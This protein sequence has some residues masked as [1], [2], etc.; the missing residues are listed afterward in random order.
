MPPGW[1][2]CRAKRAGT[3]S[4]LEMNGS[5]AFF[6]EVLTAFLPVFTP[7]MNAIAAFRVVE[8]PSCNSD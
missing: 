6:R 2:L 7:K 5:H 8:Y 1:V 4:Q 3:S